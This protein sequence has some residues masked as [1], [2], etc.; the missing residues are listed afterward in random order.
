MEQHSI[1]AVARQTGVKVPTIRYYES[2]GLLS[3]PV[4]TE[5]K[6]RR[7]DSA[8]VGRLKFIRHAREMGFEVDDI[9]Q[10]LELTERPQDSCH[11][12]D[13]IARR[14]LSS[15]EYR[16]EDLRALQSEL[17][18]MVDE[19]CHGRVCDCRILEV[20]GER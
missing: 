14:H 9:R 20:I 11:Q 5:G 12:A 8:A 16:I 6:Q 13:S 1:G 7:Y 18:R 15:I 17:G 2:I 19:C 3:A 4:R 10:L